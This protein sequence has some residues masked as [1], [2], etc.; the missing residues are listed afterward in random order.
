MAFR[1]TGV[2]AFERGK[3]AARANCLATSANKSKGGGSGLDINP[4]A[5]QAR[6]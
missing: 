4:D 2:N 5:P 3:T 6:I 1:D